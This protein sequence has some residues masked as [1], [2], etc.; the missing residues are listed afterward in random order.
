M[1]QMMPLNWIILFCYFIM[2]FFMYNIFLY[3]LFIKTQSSTMKKYK[4]NLNWKW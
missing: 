2:I 1:P 3:Y 4:L